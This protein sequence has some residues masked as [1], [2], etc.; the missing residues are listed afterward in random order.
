M[1][2][3]AYFSPMLLQNNASAVQQKRTPANLSK[4]I[5]YSSMISRPVLAEV[6]RPRDED[7]LPIKVKG[8]AALSVLQAKH[9]VENHKGSIL[10]SNGAAIEPGVQTSQALLRRPH[11]FSKESSSGLHL[12]S[13]IECSV[14]INNGLLTKSP[15][16]PIG[17]LFQHSVRSHRKVASV[18]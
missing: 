7:I 16:K 11:S 14:K 2:V 4:K 8:S 9:T 10:L 6:L 5:S 13:P 12:D 18:S 3:K 17:P 15:V 1:R